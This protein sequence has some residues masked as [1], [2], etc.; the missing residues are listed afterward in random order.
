M[1]VR[2][3]GEAPENPCLKPIQQCVAMGEH[4]PTCLCWRE[5]GHDE[6][7]L[8]IQSINFARSWGEK[9]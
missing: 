8:S 5:T 4:K 2:L 6:Y 1:K 9:V 3:L 7:C